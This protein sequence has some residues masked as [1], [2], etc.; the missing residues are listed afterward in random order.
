M[1]PPCQ[2]TAAKRSFFTCPKSLSRR[3][4]RQNQQP[5]IAF[6][7]IPRSRCSILL[8]QVLHNANVRTQL[9]AMIMLAASALADYC[10]PS[11][12]QSDGMRDIMLIYGG[13]GK[14]TKADFLPYVAYLDRDG[15]PRDW[16]YDAYLFMMYGGA[17]SGQTYID[18][19]TNK[20]DWE[21]FIAEEFAAD[22]EFA[23]LDA[24]IAHAA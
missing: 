8:M 22:R 24:A 20:A 7:N 4:L 1:Q 21:F 12:P 16:F 23:A 17:P 15:K 6:P 5:L 10:P 9:L 19:A 13:P 2:A 3:H 11:S 14:W 18:G